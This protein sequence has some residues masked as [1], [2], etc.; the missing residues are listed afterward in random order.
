[1]DKKRNLIFFSLLILSILTYYSFTFA[2]PRELEVEYPEI[3]GI[4]PET[5][6]ITLSE[7]ALYIFNIAIAAAGFVLLGSLFYGGF[8]Y[9]TSAGSPTKIKEAREKITSAFLGIGFLLAGYIILA[10]INPQLIIL[11][12]PLLPIPG[13]TPPTPP[14]QLSREVL[15]LISREIPLGQAIDGENGIFNPAKTNQTKALFEDFENFLKQEIPVERKPKRISDLNKYLKT[16]TDECQC[17][18][19]DTFCTKPEDWSLPIGCSGDPCAKETREKMKQVSEINTRKV[20]ELLEFKNRI[21]A[22]KKNLEGRQSKFGEMEQEE[23]SCR[24]QEK[25]IYSLNEY[26]NVLEFYEEQGYKADTLKGF[27]EGRGDPLSFYCSAGGTAFDFPYLPELEIPQDELPPADVS[28]EFVPQIMSC[29]VELPVGETVDK[30]RHLSILLLVKMERTML[31]IDEMVTEIRNMANLVS[32]CN[33][34][35][36]ASQCSCIPNPCYGCCS[37]IPCTVCVPFCRSRCLQAVG[38]CAGIPCPREEI[39]ET[40]KKIK[41]IE[42]EIFK[43]LDSIKNVFPEV[44]ANLQDPENDISLRNLRTSVSLCSGPVDPNT[45]APDFLLLDCESAKGNYGPDGQIIAACQP[46]NLF[47]CTPTQASL[48]AFPAVIKDRPVTIEKPKIYPPLPEVDNCPKGWLCNR[49][50]TFY[51]QYDDS[52]KPLKGL[53]SCMRQRLDK[54]QKE[55]EIEQVLGRITSIS[56]SK[57]YTETCDWTTGPTVPGGCSH[58]YT[59]RHGKEIV[60]A[61][62]GGPFCRFQE[63]SFAFDISVSSSF[64]KKYAEKIIEAAKECSPSAYIQYLTPGHYDHIHVGIGAANQCGGN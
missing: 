3:G 5:V 27:F 30:L 52:S 2:Q 28:E 9:F 1:M 7:Y 22:D 19:L 38:Q 60:S 56:D 55:E 47:C 61:H 54:T 13:P 44:A 33:E 24:A 62:Y 18:R 29:P 41:E 12:P 53:I 31:L 8:L 15:S 10:T 4:K 51:D 45:R 36:C 35:R 48:P 17:A 57:L 63:E 6:A 58:I 40:T 25:S 32:Q 43:T 16:L 37:P 14:Q 39:E 49:D 11:K 34:K 59:T 23:L 64:E 20:D 46:R 26:L 21:L 50:V 42:D